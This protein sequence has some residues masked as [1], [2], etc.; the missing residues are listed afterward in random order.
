LTIKKLR[1]LWNKKC[2]EVS[3]L[4]GAFFVHISKVIKKSFLGD[5]HTLI[6]RLTSFY[7]IW[8][9]GWAYFS[10]HSW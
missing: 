10:L 8:K 2:L 5:I 1:K 3:T 9:K 7:S 4:L 6:S